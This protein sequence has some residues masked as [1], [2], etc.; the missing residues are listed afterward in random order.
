MKLDK[1]QFVVFASY[2]ALALF[3]LNP[4]FHPSAPS[5]SVNISPAQPADISRAALVCFWLSLIMS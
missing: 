5:S 4:L 2:S 3:A 1:S